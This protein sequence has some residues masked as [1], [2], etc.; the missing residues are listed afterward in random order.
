[1]NDF[2]YAIKEYVANEKLFG[3][4]QEA[5]NFI[6]ND[7]SG[8]PVEL[9]SFRGKY[10]LV[11]FWASWCGPCRKENPNVVEAYNHYKNKNFTILSVSLDRD[12][13]KWLQAIAQDE[14][15]WTHVSDLGFWNNAVA[16]LYRIQSIPQNLLLDPD[17]KII[18]KN[19]RGETLDN[20]LSQVI[21]K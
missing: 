14:L 16:K 15:S 19:L 9:K 13:Q 20:F 6:Q 3:Y 7:P 17:G 5:P 21:K 11:D 10:V 1:L 8:Q 18:G 4:G 2:G 12:K